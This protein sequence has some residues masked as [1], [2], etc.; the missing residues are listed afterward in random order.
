MLNQ[1]IILQ[2]EVFI[3]HSFFLCL[4]PRVLSPSPDGIGTCH[5]PVLLIFSVVSLTCA[6]T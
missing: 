3:Q 2:N 5:G 1:K 6:L 4:K